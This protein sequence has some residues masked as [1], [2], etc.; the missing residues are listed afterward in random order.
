VRRRPISRR[1]AASPTKLRQP[2]Q[3]WLYCANRAMLT[4]AAGRLGEGERLAAHALA[5]GQRAQPAMAI[6]VDRLQR[7]TICD[8][9]EHLAEIEPAIRE[10]VLEYPAR[11]VFRCVLTHLHA[12]LGRPREAKRAL[13]DLAQKDFFAL[14]VDQE[15][16]YG[17]S[18]LAE[19][20]ALLD[21][22]A[23]ATALYRLLLPWAAFNVADVPEAIRGSVSRYLGILATT[24]QRWHD[25]ESHFDEA[26][27]MNE[28]TGARPWLAHTQH[29]YALML[30]TRNLP[31]KRERAHELVGAALATYRDLGMDS[32]AARTATLASEIST[33]E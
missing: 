21:D 18:L 33:R 14:P 7:Y 3:R 2:A 23:T 17:M 20:S 5:L 24:T 10:L 4:L 29:D 16:L 22:T 30:L 28:R 31:R 13:D 19:T 12:R 11:P 6:P 1:P 8:F 9:R 27:I 25:A 32:S 26:L 15:W